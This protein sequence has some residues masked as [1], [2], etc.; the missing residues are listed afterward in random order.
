[1]ARP[2]CRGGKLLFRITSAM[3]MI[4]PLPIPCSTRNRISEVLLQAKLH[5]AEPPTNTS[6]LIRKT[7]R[8]PSRLP[9]QPTVGMSTAPAIM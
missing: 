7:L 6:R 8:L 1:M 3:G 4:G 2:R 9:S 5:S